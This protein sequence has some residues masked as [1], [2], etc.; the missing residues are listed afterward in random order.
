[1]S[2]LRRNG[3]GQDVRLE[4]FGSLDSF[5]VGVDACTPMT[6][7]EPGISPPGP[8]YDQFIERFERAFRAEV[9]AFVRLVSGTGVNLTPPR[10]GLVAIQIAQAAAES[11]RAG[12]IIDLD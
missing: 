11:I 2:G 5:G 7:T 12:S 9:D 4:V 6:S 8:R 1:M 10:D 3:A